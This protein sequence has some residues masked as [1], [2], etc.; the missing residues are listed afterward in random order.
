MPAARARGRIPA[1]YAV[2]EPDG[3]DTCIVTSRGAWSHSFL[4]WMATLGESIEVLGP[5]EFAEAA[6]GLAARLSAAA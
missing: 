1:R 6:R 4:V 3:E 5:P 2:I